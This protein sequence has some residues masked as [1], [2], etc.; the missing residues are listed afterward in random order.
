[1][2]IRYAVSSIFLITVLCMVGDFNIESH[3]KE[4]SA[5]E[6]MIQTHPQPMK[7]GG[8][9]PGNCSVISDKLKKGETLGILLQRHNISAVDIHK[10]GLAMKDILSPNKIRT[11]TVISIYR[12]I[13]NDSVE[14]LN[15]NKSQDTLVSISRTEE[16]W[17]AKSVNLTLF[18]TTRQCKG[19]ITD[20]LWNSAM[21]NEIPIEIILSMADMFGWQVDFTS[22]LRKGDLYTVN[23][24]SRAIRDGGLMAGEINAARFVNDGKVFQS[25][26]FQLPD[27]S[28]EYFDESG[29][30]MRRDFLKTPLEY[31]R[32]SS[33]FSRRRFHPI[34]KIYRPHLGIDY[35]A[36]SGTPISA[37]GDGVVVYCGKR[38]GFGKYI[39]IKH[40]D[41]YETCYGHLSGY[42]KGI[43]KG[44]HV[45]QGELIGYVGATGL[46]TGP[47]LDF[48]VKYRGS[49][50][51]PNNIKSKPAKPVPEELLEQFKKKCDFWM[52]RF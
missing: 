7:P 34:L 35:A 30:S 5:I 3:S 26:R 24:N 12:N 50:I 18:S 20:S 21:K 16:D 33:G 47:H 42:K 43:H 38:G 41:A 28:F 46:A 52:K 9:L 31:R 17:I 6:G 15:I 14:K 13:E 39:Q 49:F 2:K 51:N 8:F 32:I 25:F 44:S 48:R 36:P 1:M 19:V 23:Y 29:H 45:K 40:G 10:I 27:G 37:L 22:G 11:G 4:Y